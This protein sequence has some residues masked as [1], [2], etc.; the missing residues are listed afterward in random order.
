V[1]LAA[2]MDARLGRLTPAARRTLQVSSLLGTFSTLE[3]L[4][5]VLQ[6]PRVEYVDALAQLESAGILASDP[7]GVTHGHVLWGEAALAH[8]EPSV[9]RVL[10]R[11]V[12]EQFDRELEVTPSPSIL[13][14]SARHWEAGGQVDRAMGA[15]VR[16]AEYLA[17]NGLYPEAAEAYQRAIDQASDA[18]QRRTYVRRRI[19][20]FRLSGS[21]AL[22]PREIDKHER[23]SGEIERRYDRHSD[24]EMVRRQAIYQISGANDEIVEGALACAADVAATV[25]HRL[26]AAYDCIRYGE[27]SGRRDIT[28]KGHRVLVTLTPVTPEDV[29]HYSLGESTFNFVLGDQHRAVQV[30]RAWLDFERIRG[31][32]YKISW[33]ARLAGFALMSIGD[34]AASRRAFLESIA[35]ARK[36]RL[37]LMLLCAHEEL[38]GLESEYGDLDRA[39]ECI[40]LAEKECQPFADDVPGVDFL[41]SMCRARLAIEEGDGE[42][43]LACLPTVAGN[44][45][46]RPARVVE[47][48][49]R[50]SASLLMNRP[51]EG[52]A[53]V[54]PIADQAAP[55]L[56]V[57]TYSL[58]NL[59]A[60]YAAYLDAYRGAEAAD[61]F[62][63]RFI[64]GVWRELRPTRRLAPFVERVRKSAQAAS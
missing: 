37:G 10:H 62:T 55:F 27:E 19:E 5:L 63:R 17:R 25:S 13:W 40:E 6:L 33:S 61:A 53:D 49:V 39:H 12:A 35:V 23:L 51:G 36:A 11:H 59:A 44:A 38:I 52:G 26:Q 64:D 56:A 1:T 4:E 45:G 21:W 28:E 34:V 42:K 30:A 24:L 22:I 58:G 46:A 50:L 41:L 57:P 18:R 29:Q 7:T 8:V 15:I 48:S 54:H 14:E 20:L 2:I 31:D 32:D 3:R 16:G 47:L 43:A 9:M 60:S